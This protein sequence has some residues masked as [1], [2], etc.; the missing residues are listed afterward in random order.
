MEEQSRPLLHTF[1]LQDQS[2]S[3][4][5]CSPHSKP[6]KSQDDFVR[7]EPFGKPFHRNLARSFTSHLG[8]VSTHLCACL[9]GALPRFLSPSKLSVADR[10][11]STSYLDAVRGYAA[12]FVMNHHH[13]VLW[14]TWLFQL[15]IMRGFYSGPSMVDV[16]YVIS[17]FVLTQGMI[18]KIHA[19]EPGK[20]LDSLC[21]AIFRR[22][23]RLY[24]PCVMAS[25]LSPILVSLGWGD[26][27]LG[28][29]TGNIFSQTWSWIID[30]SHYINPFAML[31]G[32]YTDES[33]RIRYLAVTWTIPVEFQGSIIAFVFLI[34]TARL[35]TRMRLGLCAITII[36]ATF[37]WATHAAMFLS[38]VFLAELSLLRYP[39]RYSKS[40]ELPVD[41]VP[42]RYDPVSKRS[43]IFERVWGILPNVGYSILFLFTFYLLGVGSDYPFFIPDPYRLFK[44]DGE[45]ELHSWA[46][47][48][49]PMLIFTLDSCQTLQIPFNTRFSQYL[50]D[51]SFG[52]YLMH[53]LVL[54]SLYTKVLA[55]VLNVQLD[56]QL[57][58]KIVV[59]LVYWLV[60]ITFADW[61]HRMDQW[62]VARV[63]WLQDRCFRAW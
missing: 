45:A 56:N 12:F 34:A 30:I 18:K 62:I 51:L 57:W 4:E 23:L 28:L 33:V 22:Y 55:D 10:L 36:A 31:R 27:T 59:S 21:S 43:H 37:W 39:E 17:G 19:R 8:E 52:I 47:I 26:D 3:F 54:H 13:F 5:L 24:V 25:F 50:G 1:E 32:Y 42:I 11:H 35:S 7:D 49:A 15:P 60:V 46:V 2:S 61:F 29:P 41:N 44:G 9:L 38:G 16:F 20:L 53:W 63:K 48:A 40:P 6:C 14:D 58:A